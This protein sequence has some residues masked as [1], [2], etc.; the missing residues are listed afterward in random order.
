MIYTVTFNLLLDYIVSVDDFYNRG[1]WNG[2][3]RKLFTRRKGY[4]CFDGVKI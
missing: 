2:Q 4:Q 3:R 1:V